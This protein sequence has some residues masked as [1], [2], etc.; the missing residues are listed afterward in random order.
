MSKLLAFHCGRNTTTFCA[1]C[2]SPRMLV[3]HRGLRTGKPL[4]EAFFSSMLRRLAEVQCKAYQ[5]LSKVWHAGIAYLDPGNLESQLQAG[6]QAGYDLI[7][8]LL[9][10]IIMVCSLIILLPL[11]LQQIIHSQGPSPGLG[12]HLPA[13]SEHVRLW[14][15]IQMALL[16]GLGLCR[17]TSCRS[18]QS[19]WA[20][21]LA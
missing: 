17:A 4:L 5:W 18:C 8:V 9:W 2:C 14:L 12:I 16:M 7:W 21:R 10:V 13:L 11:S 1:V 3:I 15:A 6:A 20:S 19:S